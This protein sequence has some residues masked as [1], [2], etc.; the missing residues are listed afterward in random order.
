M[1]LPEGPRTPKGASAGSKQHD[2]SGVSKKKGI[3]GKGAGSLAKEAKFSQDEP[4]PFTQRP[5]NAI[6]YGDKSRKNKNSSS[7]PRQPKQARNRASG[8]G[9][10][11]PGDANSIGRM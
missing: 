9:G 2:G 11:T 8:R 6:P 4:D 5:L 3:K 7:T 10:R 1:K